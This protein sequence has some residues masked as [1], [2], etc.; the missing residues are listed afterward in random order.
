MIMNVRLS[1]SARS[2][3]ALACIAALAVLVLAGIVNPLAAQEPEK[4]D[5]TQTQ[6]AAA[7]QPPSEGFKFGVYEGHSE[8]E[9]GYRAVD[10]ISGS[11]DVYR[12]MINLGEGPKLLRS[13][14]SLRSKYG[15]GGLFDRLDLSLNNWG[16][17]PYNTFHLNLGKSDKYELRV[18]YRNLNYYNFLPTYANPLLAQG[19]LQ[20]QHGLDVTYR[21]TDIQFKLFPTSRFRPYVAYSRASGF[22]PGYTTTSTETNEFPLR[23][24]WHYASD[25]YR[26]GIEMSFSRLSLVFEQGYRRLKNDTGVSD[27]QD[28]A[29]NYTRPYLGQVVTMSSLDRGYHD[30]TTLPVTRVVAK[31]SPFNWLN[32]TGRYIYSTADTESALGE[33]RSGNLITLEDRLSYR[34]AIDAFNTKASKPSHNAALTAEFSPLSNLTILDQFDRRSYHVSGSAVL[35][36]AYLNASPLSGQTPSGPDT[37]VSRLLDSYLSFDQTRNQIEAELAIGRGF[38]LRGGHRYT[39]TRVTLSN[40]ENGDTASSEADVAQQTGIFGLWYRPTRRMHFGVDYEVNSSDGALTR[41]DLLNY[42]QV[43]FD[44]QF[45]PLKNLSLSGRVGLLKNRNDQPDIDLDSHNRNYSFALNYDFNQ[46]INFTLDYQ[47]S[48]ILSNLAILLPQTLKEDR[49]IYDERGS[50]AGGTLGIDFYKGLRADIGLRAILNAGDFPLKYYQP[51][52]SITV[53][54]RNGLAVRTMWQDFAYNESNSTLQDF[55]TQLY[56]FSLIYSR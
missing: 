11:E 35:D 40:G 26:G 42:H 1:Y 33:V 4:K 8:I 52:A 46:R 9:V 54:L 6:A 27:V 13:S 24:N 48:N 37:N 39:S 18:D 51:F 32:L 7:P 45:D 47:H 10:R 3:L 53:P 25:D 50:A 14:L 34:A 15:T 29:G 16:G 17:D 31:Y 23:T 55:R 28:P 44:W 41:T 43:N 20:G 56:T 38:S 36:T 21:S 49:S 2:R 30:R 19:N 5:D 12:S 22:G